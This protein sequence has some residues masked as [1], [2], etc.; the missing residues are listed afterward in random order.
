MA[1]L[2]YELIWVKQFLQDL[3]F[4]DIQLMKMYCDN[5]TALHID[6]RFIREKLLS[7]EV[8]TKFV[9]SNDRLADALKKF[10]KGLQIQFICTKLGTYNL[11][12][13]T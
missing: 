6:F 4:C 5:Q 7:K 12:V 2:T 10:L 9:G 8:C 1:S 3:D 13:S 11:Y